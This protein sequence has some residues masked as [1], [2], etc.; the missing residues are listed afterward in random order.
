MLVE[1]VGGIGGNGGP[2][3]GGM[4]GGKGG[5]IFIGGKGGGGIPEKKE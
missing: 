4:P 3:V 5:C 2:L 1:D